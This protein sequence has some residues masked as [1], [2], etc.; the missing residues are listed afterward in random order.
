MDLKLIR[1]ALNEGAEYI[2]EVTNND[3][4]IASDI[5]DKISSA[6]DETFK[7]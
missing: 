6:F 1:E 4:E 5:L 2:M 3:S 7:K